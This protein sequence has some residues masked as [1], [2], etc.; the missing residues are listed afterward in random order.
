MNES[1]ICSWLDRDANDPSFQLMMND[2][3]CDHILLLKHPIK[4][5]NQKKVE[6]TKMLQQ[7]F[8]MA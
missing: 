3:V 7:R 1:E 5:K 4:K 6:C 2:E 8:L